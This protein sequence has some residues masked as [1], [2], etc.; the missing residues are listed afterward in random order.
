MKLIF[1][2]WTKIGHF[3]NMQISVFAVLYVYKLD[4]LYFKKNLVCFL[5]KIKYGHFK[6]LLN[7]HLD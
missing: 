2:L 5:I 4:N 6:I 3:Q 7:K 1:E